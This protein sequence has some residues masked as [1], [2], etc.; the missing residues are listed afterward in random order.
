MEKYGSSV[1]GYER[2]GTDSNGFK[3]GKEHGVNLFVSVGICCYPFMLEPSGSVF[4]PFFLQWKSADT[5]RYEQTRTDWITNR[6]VPFLSHYLCRRNPLTTPQRL[7]RRAIERHVRL[8]PRGH[9]ERCGHPL[10]G[11][12]GQLVAVVRRAE[13]RVHGAGN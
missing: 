13:Q 2:I 1:N 3:L 10:A 9:T 4:I 5:N 11:V 8:N 6:L 7:Q 12:R